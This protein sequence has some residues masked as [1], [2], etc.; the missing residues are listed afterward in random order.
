MEANPWRDIRLDVYES[1]MSDQS[2]GQLDLLRRI[3]ADQLRDHPSRRIGILGIAGGNGLDEVDPTRIDAL[4][5]YDI[6]PDYL[7][8]CRARYGEAFGARMQLRECSIDR[9]LTIEPTDLLLANL[10]IEYVG[11]PE[12]AAFVAANSARI[13]ILSCVTQQNGTAGLVSSTRY[14]AA[15]AGLASVASEVDPGGLTAALTAV[16]LSLTAQVEHPLPNGKLLT[17]QD[18]ATAR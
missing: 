13:G 6:N 12:F 1:H 17:R 5:G 2:V 3:T 18:F 8:A 11:L 15:F 14:S 10:I 7:D 9:S 4:T 16:G